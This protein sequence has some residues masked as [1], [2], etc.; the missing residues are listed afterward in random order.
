MSYSG[1]TLCSALLWIS[2]S[3][4]T[5]GIK[6]MR[7]M[8]QL[9]LRHTHS[10]THTHTRTHTCAHTCT[11]THTHTHTRTHARTHARTHTHAD[12]INEHHP[13]CQ[14]VLK[15][16]T[17]CLLHHDRRGSTFHTHIQTI[18]SI[19][20]RLRLEPISQD[21]L[22]S[23]LLNGQEWDRVGLSWF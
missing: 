16:Q 20:H 11:H 13:G 12:H 7:N 6:D 8:N 18:I 22:S 1:E 10:H 17:D 9:S 23:L 15:L 2:D 4:L 21:Q 3:L 14:A 19:L 5:E